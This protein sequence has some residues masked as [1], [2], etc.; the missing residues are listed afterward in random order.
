MDIFYN[1]MR[2]LVLEDRMGFKKVF[3]ISV[4]DSEF[5][6]KRVHDNRSFEICANIRLTSQ[7]TRCWMKTSFKSIQQGNF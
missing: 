4:E 3:Q 2:E 1:I 7:V 5:V 6:L